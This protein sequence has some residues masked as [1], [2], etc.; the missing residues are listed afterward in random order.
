MLFLK[1]D[2]GRQV[3]VNAFN[4]SRTYARLMMGRP[5]AQL[6]ARILADAVNERPESWGNPATHLI[7]PMVD[8]SA[9]E[10]PVLPPVLLRALLTCYEPVD[11]AFMG[12][13]LEVVWLTEECHDKSIEEVVARTVRGVAW[14]KLASD[15][16]W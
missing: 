6:N 4:Y 10:H 8:S 2:C 16:D 14:E 9:P 7:T 3:S 13:V 15:F 12:S 5:D 1:L 11:P